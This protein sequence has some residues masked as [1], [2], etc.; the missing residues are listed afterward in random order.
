MNS[1]Q[2]MESDM[3]TYELDKYAKWEVLSWLPYL[4]Q[5]NYG[6]TKLV[7]MEISIQLIYRQHLLSL[8]Q[9]IASRLKVSPKRGRRDYVEAIRTDV[10][11]A[12]QLFTLVDTADIIEHLA[13]PEWGDFMI[14]PDD[15]QRM[16]DT[17]PPFFPALVPVK[18]TAYRLLPVEDCPFE[19]W[20]M[21]VWWEENRAEDIE[22]HSITT[23]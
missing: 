9:E 17:L 11:L 1:T 14:A 23:F 4:L 21:L 19:G 12:W 22:S 2:Q 10:V 13:E 20:P 16:G 18:N 7:P 3:K 8:L 5:V 6:G 15:S